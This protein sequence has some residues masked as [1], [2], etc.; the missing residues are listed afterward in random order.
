MC[1]ILKKSTPRKPKP[2]PQ[3]PPPI[4]TTRKTQTNKQALQ[5]I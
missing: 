2:L 4:K 3:P 5:G 1:V